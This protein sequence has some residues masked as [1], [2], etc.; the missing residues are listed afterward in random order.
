MRRRRK[1]AAAGHGKPPAWLTTFTAAD[2]PVD[3]ASPPP[4]VDPASAEDV[5]TWRAMSARRRWEAAG[6]AWL[7]QHGHGVDAWYRLTRPGPAVD[8]GHQDPPTEG[9]T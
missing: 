5:A 2:W 7:D 8:R 9:D 3:L 4:Y 6:R 1:E